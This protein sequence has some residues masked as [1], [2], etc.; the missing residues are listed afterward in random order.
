ME[1]THATTAAPASTTSGTAETAPARARGRLTRRQEEALAAIRRHI[2]QHGYPPTVRELAR[3]LGLRSPSSAH[4]LLGEL[5]ANGHIRRR[6]RFARALD[7]T[8][9]S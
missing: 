3:A 7:V 9:P 2:A 1:T 6:E 8:P 5:E 4:H